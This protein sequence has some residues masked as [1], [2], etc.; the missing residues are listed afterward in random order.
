MAGHS[1][2]ANIRFRKG[3]QDA[4]RGKIFTKIIREITVATKMQG[5]DT[6]SNPRL[7][8]AI[9]KALKAN[10]KRD[11]IDNAIKRGS[12][13]M[14]DKNFEDIRY[15]GYGPKGVAIMVDCLTDN[16]NRTV[17]EVRHLLTKYGGNLGSDGSVSYLFKKEGLI[18]I[19]GPVNEEKLMELVDDDMED[20]SLSDDG[21]MELTVNPKAIH[22]IKERLEQ[23]QFNLD[24]VETAMVASTH[25]DLDSESSQSLVKLLDM[26]EDLDDVQQVY[27]NASFPEDVKE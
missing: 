9:T 8:D 11:T 26:L 17:A 16:R 27:S 5:P 3:A 14:G 2:W 23:H 25:V 22:K 4:K 7:R 1:K 21:T 19:P 20:M 18:T 6:D 13:D 15:E 24:V 10:M 12:G